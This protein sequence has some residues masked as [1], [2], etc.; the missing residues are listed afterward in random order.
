[1]NVA[2]TAYKTTAKAAVNGEFKKVS[3]RGKTTASSLQ[4]LAKQV[5]VVINR[6]SADTGNAGRDK[7]LGE[8]FFSK[9]K[10]S[11][12]H[13]KFSSLDE[14]AH[15]AVLTLSFNGKTQAVPMKYEWT[16]PAGEFT[17]TG[18]MDILKFGGDSAL[19]SLAKQCEKLHTG[20][21]GVAKT[22]SEVSLKLKGK[23][24]SSNCVLKN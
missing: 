21:D 1:V 23:V 11:A 4:A 15:T 9:L 6:A 13:G 20:K 18:E 16:A 17:A 22:W 5:D 14:K 2:W 8:F 3:V 24:T 10:P 19:A 7:T 12:I